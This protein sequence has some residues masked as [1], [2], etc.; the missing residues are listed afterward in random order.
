MKTTRDA[1]RKQD[2][3]SGLE[4]LHIQMLRL[5]ADR[6]KARH[7]ARILALHVTQIV[8]RVIAMRE[9]RCTGEGLVQFA[10]LL[11]DSQRLAD[12]VIYGE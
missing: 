5:Q 2:G 4:P 12:A 6:I 1:G 9:G 10:E 8:A 11:R 7:Q 3:R